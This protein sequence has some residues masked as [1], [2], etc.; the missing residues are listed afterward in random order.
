MNVSR[1]V[2]VSP[3][4]LAAI[5]TGE[6]SQVRSVVPSDPIPSPHEG[7]IGFVWYPE[8]GVQS[9]Y[10]WGATLPNLLLSMV[11]LGYSPHGEPGEVFGFVRDGTLGQSLDADLQT[12]LGCKAK[13][14]RSW[15]ERLD[16]ASHDSLIRLGHPPMSGLSY[17][18]LDP[19][20]DLD[21]HERLLAA[22]A[23]LFEGMRRL[24]GAAL[25]RPDSYSWCCDFEVTEVL[26]P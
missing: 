9:H 23:E 26:R 11:N 5:C 15:V 14:V 19:D 4:A 22:R 20:T 10:V 21:E 13:V 24:F 2:R 25:V 8:A 16:Q 17:A 6:K 3:S 1:I 18:G 7:G 12:P